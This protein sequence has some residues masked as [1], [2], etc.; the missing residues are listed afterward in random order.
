[1]ASGN[2]TALLSKSAK[3]ASSNSLSSPER[4][5]AEPL[6]WD[7]QE[8]MSEFHDL[9]QNPPVRSVV[10]EFHPD[11]ASQLLQT[12]NKKN[13]PLTER[14]VRRLAADF[15]ESYELT[16]DTIKFSRKGTLLDGQH[17]LHACVKDNRPLLTHVV[18]GIEDRVFDVLDQGRKRTA[19]DV[20]ALCGVENHTTI[21]A[22]INYVRYITSG[23]QVDG[24][25]NAL[26]PRAIRRLAMGEMK[27]IGRYVK[28]A[29]LI[30][31]A[32]KHPPSI[33]TA[34]LYLIGQHREALAHEFA[35]EWVHGARVGRNKNFDVLSGRFISITRQS[36][37]VL[38]RAVRAALMIQTFNHWNA[39]VVA[40]PQSLRWQ[41]G[42][43]FPSLIFDKEVFLRGKREAEKRDTSLS[44][45]QLRVLKAMAEGSEAGLCTLSHAEI[46]K[47]ANTPRGT[48]PYILSTLV[49]DDLIERESN[50]K[51]RINFDKMKEGAH[52]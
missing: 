41:K 2:G 19:A 14:F 45:T 7:S 11:I 46:G 27:D 30:N 21:A 26:S 38:N 5:F 50:G 42:L 33:V 37:G 18:F 15:H 17:R 29:M 9:V 12:C 34:L 16:G 39:H 40:S 1:M 8:A 22:A 28:D 52:A 10:I 24:G 35:Q 51:Y 44:A 31:A 25:S 36:G 48:V 43:K 13:R 3:G 49:E 23:S 47:A 4:D 32:Y 6:V 20:L